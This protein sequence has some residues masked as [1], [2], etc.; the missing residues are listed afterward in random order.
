MPVSEP[1]FQHA[2]LL[3]A[4]AFPLLWGR[5]FAVRPVLR[6]RMSRATGLTAP[7]GLTEALLVPAHWNPPSLFKR[8]RGT[9]FDIE[10]F[11]SCFATGGSGAVSHRALAPMPMRHTD[12]QARSRPQHRWHQLALLSSVMVFAA[13]IRIDWNPIDPGILALTAGAAAA[14]F[15]RGDL[16]CQ[17]LRASG[18]LLGSVAAFLRGLKWW[19]PGCIEARWSLDALTNRRPGGSPMEESWFG[20]DFGMCWSSVIEHLS[21]RQREIAVLGAVCTHLGCIP[22]FRPAAGAADIGSAWPGGFYCPCHGSKFDFAGRVFK[23]V[24]AP[25]NLTV[26]PYQFASD[27]LLVIGVES[28]S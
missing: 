9:G 6:R 13:L 18:V 22:S 11:I 4:R 3:W 10:S 23:N 5:A 16:R 26:P 1:T 25:T 12:T 20:P 15:C 17:T 21:W 27:S 2:R 8:A 7:F 24:P 14:L 28:S 19:W